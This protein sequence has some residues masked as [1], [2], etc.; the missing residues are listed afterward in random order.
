MNLSDLWINGILNN[1]W[2]EDPGLLFSCTVKND[3][4]RLLVSK[5]SGRDIE[6]A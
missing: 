1:I 6:S 5:Y 4:N 3:K 2:I